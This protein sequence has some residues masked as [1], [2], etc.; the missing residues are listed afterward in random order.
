MHLPCHVVARQH[1]SEC[2]CD[3]SDS[4]SIGANAFRISDGRVLSC[5][6]FHFMSYF[7]FGSMGYYIE[8]A[9]TPSRRL[10]SGDARGPRSPSRQSASLLS[11][12]ARNGGHRGLWIWRFLPRS[13]TA[14]TS[15]AGGARRIGVGRRGPC[16]HADSGLRPHDV[17]PSVPS[18]HE[19]GGS[20]LPVKTTPT[21]VMADDGGV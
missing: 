18:S 14:W 20:R 9:R 1:T 10:P 21:S 8:P 19:I 3:G 16:R 7:L 11:A 12:A 2:D 4:H 17:P 6:H 15:S 13:A 5:C